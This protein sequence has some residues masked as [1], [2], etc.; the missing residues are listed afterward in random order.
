MWAVTCKLYD[1]R[2]NK[3]NYILVIFQLYSF[4]LTLLFHLIYL[5]NGNWGTWQDWNSCSA[6]CGSGSRSR[7]HECNSSESAHGGSTCQGND[8]EIN[9]CSIK[10][11]PG[12]F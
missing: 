4:F 12:K 6:T 7:Y 10:L 5:V 11:C 2:D 3:D 9:S 8:T 1:D